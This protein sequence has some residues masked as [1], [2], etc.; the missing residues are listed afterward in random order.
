M[1]V[2]SHSVIAFV[3]I[4]IRITYIA[5]PRILHSILSLR[6]TALENE[7]HLRKNRFWKDGEHNQI[8]F[9]QP[10]EKNKTKNRQQ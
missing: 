9:W 4:K 2:S 1:Y 3:Q 5:P 10:K 7:I 8:K 6:L